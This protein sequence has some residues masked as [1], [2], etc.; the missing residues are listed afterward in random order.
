MSAN[1]GGAN[2]AQFGG[3]YGQSAQPNAGPGPGVTIATGTLGPGGG[4]GLGAN[5][6]A[7]YGSIEMHFG[8]EHANSGSIAVTWPG[9]PPAMVYSAEWAT[10]SQAGDEFTVLTWT[11][12][13]NPI[14]SGKTYRIWYQQAV[15][16]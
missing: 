15:L 12:A 9:I 3:S 10:I 6:T 5:S 1:L 8:P 4:I 11:V 7:A 2:A 16:D 14:V 13:G